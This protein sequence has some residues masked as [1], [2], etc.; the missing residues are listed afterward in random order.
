MTAL[1]VL[2]FLTVVFMITA[3]LADHAPHITSLSRL[4]DKWFPEN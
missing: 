3:A 1:L 2:A 4:A